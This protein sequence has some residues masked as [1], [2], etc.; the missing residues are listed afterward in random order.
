MTAVWWDQSLRHSRIQDWY[1]RLDFDAIKAVVLPIAAKA[2]ETSDFQ[3]FALACLTLVAQIPDGHVC[4]QCENDEMK[5][6]VNKAR[7]KA[8]GGGFG[9]SIT[10][11]EDGEVLVIYSSRGDIQVGDTVTALDGPPI[12]SYVQPEQLLSSL[13]YCTVRCRI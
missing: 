12:K 4:L 7:D 11:V 2:Q 9:F 1:K 6:I 5:P 8:L 10:E 13:V 3:L